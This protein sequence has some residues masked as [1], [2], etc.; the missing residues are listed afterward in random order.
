MTSFRTPDIV[1]ALSLLYNVFIQINYCSNQP[2]SITA[3]TKYFGKSLQW[4]DRRQQFF[5]LI[6]YDDLYEYLM[7]LFKAHFSISAAIFC[8]FILH[9]LLCGSREYLIFCTCMIY[10]YDHLA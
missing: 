2:F 1:I 5:S 9:V 8:C 3:E 7:F 10:M 4:F 6:L